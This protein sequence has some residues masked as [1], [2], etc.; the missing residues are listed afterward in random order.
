MVNRNKHM[1][2]EEIRQDEPCNNNNIS[3]RVNMVNTSIRGGKCFVNKSM[4]GG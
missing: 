4:I 3:K 2:G 1:R